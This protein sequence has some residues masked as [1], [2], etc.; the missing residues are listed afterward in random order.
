[1]NKLPFLNLY[2]ISPWK[3]DGWETQSF[4]FSGIP[5]PFSEGICQG[6]PWTDRE[7]TSLE[8]KRRKLKGSKTN[9]R[10]PGSV[11]ATSRNWR[12][13][14]LGEKNGWKVESLVS[15]LIR[16]NLTKKKWGVESPKSH[17]R[18]LSANINQLKINL[19]N[20]HHGQR[21][22]SRNFKRLQV[23]EFPFAGLPST[24]AFLSKFYRDEFDYQTS[25]MEDWQLDVLTLDIRKMAGTSSI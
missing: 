9:A 8:G 5:A 3:L 15:W 1:M 16:L 19:T 22:N 24:W 20:W 7:G 18:S 4:P 13:L 17:N 11:S 21:V 23:L 25:V 6:I 10:F 12:S 14:F 2:N